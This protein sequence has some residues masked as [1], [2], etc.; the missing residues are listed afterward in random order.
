MYPIHELTLK[1][2]CLP[3]PLSATAWALPRAL[4]A[5]TC[6][7]ATLPQRPTLNACLDHHLACMSPHIC[8]T[9]GKYVPGCYAMS[10]NDEL[11]ED[12]QVRNSNACYRKYIV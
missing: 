9:A 12:L 5:S 6:P 2:L 10:V 8:V 7:A 11:P 3:V 4:Q 1:A